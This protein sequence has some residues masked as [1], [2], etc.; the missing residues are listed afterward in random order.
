MRSAEQ[1]VVP[2]KW[3]LTLQ[4]ALQRF[5]VLQLYQLGPQP[6]VRSA[7]A[8]ATTVRS[9]A[10]RA[11]TVRSTTARPTTVRSTTSSGHNSS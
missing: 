8:R 3:W 11:T 10:A 2:S 5:V 1:V 7:T 4:F 9:T 6:T